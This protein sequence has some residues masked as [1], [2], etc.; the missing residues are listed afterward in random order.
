LFCLYPFAGA[1]QFSRRSLLKN[2]CPQLQAIAH[3]GVE[4]FKHAKHTLALGVEVYRLPSSSP[5]NAGW[6]FERKLHAWRDVFVQ[7]GLAVIGSQ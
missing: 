3:N 6:S 4:S 7:A 5:A 2:A 1:G